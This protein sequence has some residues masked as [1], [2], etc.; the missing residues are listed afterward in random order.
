MLLIIMIYC[1]NSHL[2]KLLQS[3]VVYHFK[4]L[5][6]ILCHCIPYDFCYKISHYFLISLFFS[7]QILK[8]A[9]Q[10]CL[11]SLCQLNPVI[12]A[13]NNFPENGHSQHLHQSHTNSSPSLCGLSPSS[14]KYF[15]WLFFISFSPF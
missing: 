8:I 15:P 11:G 14:P 6:I 7:F 3:F 4:V 2:K 12:S 9:E 10:R 1:V 5:H 13:F